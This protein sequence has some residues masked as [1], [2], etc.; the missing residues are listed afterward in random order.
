MKMLP[1]NTI[2]VMFTQ[3]CNLNCSYCFEH[4]KDGINIKA[5]DTF[6]IM[7]NEGKYDISPYQRI[8]PIGGEALLNMDWIINLQK[9]IKDYPTFSKKYKE[10]TCQGISHLITNGTLI[11]KYIDELVDNNYMLQISIDGPKEVHDKC[12]VD[13]NGK[14]SYDRIM[15]NV[16]E[17]EERNYPN[18]VF[19]GAIDSSNFDKLFEIVKMSLHRSP[20]NITNSLYFITK[21]SNMFSF[22]MENDFTDEQVN[23]LIEN[24]YKIVDYILNSEEMNNWPKDFRIKMATSFLARSASN[25]CAAGSC[26][27]M[28]DSNNKVY[29]CHRLNTFNEDTPYLYDLNNNTVGDYKMYLLVMD[30]LVDKFYGAYRS[31]SKR[32][33]EKYEYWAFACP[34]TNYNVNKSVDYIPAKFNVV[35]AELKRAVV[36][37]ADYFDL[38]LDQAAVKLEEYKKWMPERFFN[39]E[40]S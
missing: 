6:N 12:R 21:S 9:M 2:S 28:L 10:N 40:A 5:E 20:D 27:L 29:G 16:K 4:I 8:F 24:I 26:M 18:Y 39:D 33:N 1:L 17:L 15:E 38:D 3:K 37:I 34:M 11:N 22:I 35:E 25:V 7:T 32:N 14:G 23:S 19:H 31:F 13:Y 30:R 36:Q